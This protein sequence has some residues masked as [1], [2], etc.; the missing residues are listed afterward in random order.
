MIDPLAIMRTVFLPG[1]FNRNNSFKEDEDC[2]YM[3]GTADQNV[4]LSFLLLIA[5]SHSVEQSKT[6]VTSLLDFI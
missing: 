3:Y 2:I 5:V 6:F 4:L 1:N